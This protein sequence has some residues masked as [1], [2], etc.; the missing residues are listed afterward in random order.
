MIAYALLG[1]PKE[2]WPIDIKDILLKA[3]NNHDLIIGVDRGSLL[4]EELGITPDLA[5]GDYDSLKKAE[6]AQI[7]HSVADIRYSNPIKNYTDSE[8]M[9]RIAFEEYQVDSLVILGATGGRIDHFLVNMFMML[10][11]DVRQYSEKI[12]LLDRQNKIRYY[13]PG[14]HK[15]AWENYPY[16]GVATL[17]AVDNLT[18][19]EA[20]YHLENY[21]VAYPQIFSS[22]EFADKGK[23]FKLS[24]AKG[25][26]SVIFSKD[27]ERFYHLNN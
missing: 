16:F 24:F 27:L 12:V 18:I 14:Q 25:M 26:V 11:P 23:D 9:I 20:K 8:L 1:G 4:L 7:E 3:Q 6:L 2:E 19:A 13:L 10:N 22:N 17:S 15:I 21:S 5:V